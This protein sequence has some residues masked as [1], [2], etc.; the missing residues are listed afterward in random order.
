MKK[1][2]ITGGIGSGKTTVCEIFKL[3]GV[4]V[5]H[6]DAEA[7]ILQNNDLHIKDLLIRQFGI[8][9]YSPEGVL[10]RKKM[11]ELIFNDSEALAKVNS[12]IHPAVRQS[13]LKWSESHQ[14]APYILYEAAILLESG[15]ASDFEKNILV[16]ADEKVRIDRVIRRDHLSEKLI[17]QR[18]NNQMPDEIKINLVD[19]IIENNDEKL[20]IPQIIE[21]DKLIR[22]DGKNR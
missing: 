9:I 17:K 15:Y 7:K 22:S 5:F 8:H 14:D 11:A 3:L 13:F 10:D 6:A 4:P 16:L 2:G 18:I 20:L 21:L 19:Y 12:I 1:I